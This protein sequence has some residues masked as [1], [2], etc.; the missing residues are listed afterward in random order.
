[1]SAPDV[2][3]I[4]HGGGPLPLL[5]DSQHKEMVATLEYIS[6][7]ID[8]PKAIVVISAHWETDAVTVHTAKSPEL[9][10]DYHG[11]PKPAYEID[12]PVAGKPDLANALIADLQSAGI[13][14]MEEQARGLDHG[15]FVPLKIMYPEADIPVVQVSL[16]NNLDPQ[17]HIQIGRVLREVLDENV[18][19]IGSGFSFHNMKA[20]GMP[21]T[22]DIQSQNQAFEDWLLDT[23]Y[24]EDYSE[25]ERENRLVA[26][27]K[28]PYARFCHPREEHLLPLHVCYGVAQK[29]ADAYF[30][31]T[32]LGK[33]A[34]MFYWRKH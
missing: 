30:S 17:S 1:M 23:C 9:L 18:L 5:G 8:R 28:A 33:K 3:F 19:V 32:I 29:K 10:Y 21:S 6:T 24:G 14:V 25:S 13:P 31:A 20:F 27:E 34:G 16:L 12:Y 22:P 7:S 4:S 26:W 15:V 2:L 11:F